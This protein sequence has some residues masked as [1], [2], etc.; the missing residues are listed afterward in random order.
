MIG[1]DVGVKVEIIV[2]T[3][4]ALSLDGQGNEAFIEG[5]VA[6]GKM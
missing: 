4:D 1:E 6:A 5:R 3:A 2:M